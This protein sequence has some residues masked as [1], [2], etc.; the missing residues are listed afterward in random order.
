MPIQM[1]INGELVKAGDGKVDPV[2]NPSTGTAFDTVPSATVE[3]LNNAV[4]AAKTAFKTWSKTPYPERAAALNKFA[5]L[6]ESRAQEFA[7]RL[8]QCVRRAR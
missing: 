6:L 1:V 3:D 4:S 5:D 7:G 2:I 8:L